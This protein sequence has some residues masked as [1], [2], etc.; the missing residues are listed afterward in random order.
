MISNRCAPIRQFW[1]VMS[2]SLCRVAG[3]VPALL[4]SLVLVALIVKGETE[5]SAPA[6]ILG[7]NLSDALGGGFIAISAVLGALGSFFSGSTTVSNL[8]FGRVQVVRVP[9]SV[10][11]RASYLPETWEDCFRL[12]QMKWGCGYWCFEGCFA[13]QVANG[14]DSLQTVWS[15]ASTEQGRANS[16]PVEKDL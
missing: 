10:S 1:L 13:Q 11:L 9:N 3:I 12:L 16:R 15:G 8:T 14:L 4:G 6:Y 7:S 2:K 5:A